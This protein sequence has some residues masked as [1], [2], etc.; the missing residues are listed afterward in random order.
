MKFYEWCGGVRES[1]PFTFLG[2]NSRLIAVSLHHTTTE[3]KRTEQTSAQF[4]A[5]FFLL[6]VVKA[7]IFP[8]LP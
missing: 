5:F 2:Y 8:S 7:V 4:V 3:Q 1:C 6:L